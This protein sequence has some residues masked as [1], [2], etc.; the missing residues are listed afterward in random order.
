MQILNLIPMLKIHFCQISWTFS[1][2][3]QVNAQST[4][5]QKTFDFIKK[6]KK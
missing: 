4:E 6:L 2:I 1:E 3:E 5:F